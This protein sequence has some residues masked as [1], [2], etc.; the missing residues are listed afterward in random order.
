MKEIVA[1]LLSGLVIAVA[2]AAAAPRETRA[3][4]GPV[5]A[6]GTPAAAESAASR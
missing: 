6:P 4:R 5:A 3:Q 2:I 1:G